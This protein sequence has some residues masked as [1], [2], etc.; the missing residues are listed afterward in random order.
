[1]RSRTR[2]GMLLLS[3]GAVASITGC[4]ALGIHSR[5]YRVAQKYRKE[6]LALTARRTEL[7]TRL[8]AS[9]VERKTAQSKLAF[10]QDTIKDLKAKETETASAKTSAAGRFEELM[11]QLQGLGH[12]VASPDG[13]RGV[14]LTSDLLFPPG[15]TVIKTSAVPL[16]SKVARVIRQLDDGVVVFVDGHTD[17]DPLRITKK[18]Y[19]DNYGLGAARANAVARKLVELGAPRDRLVTRSFGK[20]NP[21]ASNRTRSGKGK[22][23]R[24]E[25]TFALADATRVSTAR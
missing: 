22:N 23:R 16:L 7:E 10:L 8:A 17:S 19:H 6:N 15:K 13:H 14:R 2:W 3:V 1:M 11:A 4:E 18:L 21:I 20:D 12:P 5:S 24:V 9:E 25:V